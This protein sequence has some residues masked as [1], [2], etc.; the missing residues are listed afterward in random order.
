MSFETEMEAALFTTMTT[1]VP[2]EPT[3]K[4]ADTVFIKTDYDGSSNAS[5]VFLSYTVLRVFLKWTSLSKIAD[6][7]GND[8]DGSG[9]ASQSMWFYSIQSDATSTLVVEKHQSELDTLANIQ[10]LVGVEVGDWA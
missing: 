4:E 2:K 8:A 3:F 1:N 5:F 7:N 10:T 6:L 9:S